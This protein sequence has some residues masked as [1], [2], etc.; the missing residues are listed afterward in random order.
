M[1]SSCTIFTL[2]QSFQNNKPY[3]RKLM[4]GIS[5][6]SMLSPQL[7]R[8]LYSMYNLTCTEFHWDLKFCDP[9]EKQV[10][11]RAG[12]QWKLFSNSWVGR[13]VYTFWGQK[14]TQIFTMQPWKE[15]GIFFFFLFTNMM[16][17]NKVTNLNPIN[18]IWLQIY[19]SQYNSD[20]SF[21]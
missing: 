11:R 10:L 16:L 6:V 2:S 20:I 14:E 13:Q 9:I 15:R 3:H 12:K 17:Q 8:C 19:F 18:P 5:E 7:Y 1:K 21:N 4:K